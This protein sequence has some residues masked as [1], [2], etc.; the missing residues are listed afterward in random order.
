MLLA[1]WSSI[2]DPSDFSTDWTCRNGRNLKGNNYEIMLATAVNA[3][4]LQV[5][6]KKA[7]AVSR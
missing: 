2:K 4:T 7:M 1:L 3:G 5:K 6:G